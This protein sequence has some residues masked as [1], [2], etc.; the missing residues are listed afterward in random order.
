MGDLAGQL[1]MVASLWWVWIIVACFSAWH[2]A[3]IAYQREEDSIDPPWIRAALVFHGLCIAA[4]LVLLLSS[5]VKAAFD[6]FSG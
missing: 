3:C 2:I 1:S 5:M 6:T 4:M